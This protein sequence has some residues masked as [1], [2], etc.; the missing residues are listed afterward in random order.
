VS[1]PIVY[2][3][4]HIGPYNLPYAKWEFAHVD[5]DG[6]EDNRCGTADSLEDCIDL[7]DVLED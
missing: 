6:P 2:R 1:H 4:F 5:Y 7:I 3:G